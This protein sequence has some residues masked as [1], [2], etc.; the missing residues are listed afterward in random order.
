MSLHDMSWY[1]IWRLMPLVLAVLVAA[2]SKGGDK[3]AK[4][5]PAPL[6]SVEKV[7]VR[8]VAVE[9]RAPVD[10]RPL[11]QAD[12]GSKQLGYLDAVLV[13]R[14]DRV[15]KGQVVAL[16]RP[17]DLPDQLSAAR[18]VVAQSEASVA[19]ARVNYERA[20][21]LAPNGVVSQQAL[22]SAQAA[23]ATAEASHAAAKAQLAALAV[24][25]GETRIESPLDGLVA[26]RRLDP[27][28]LVGPTGSPS[29]LTVV[30]T[31]TLRVFIAVTERD[32]AGVKLGDDARVEVDALPGRLFHGKVMRI[33]PAFDPTTRT[34]D[35]EVHLA[36]ESGELRPGMYGRGAIVLATHP[37]ALSVPVGAVQI[38]SDKHYAYVLVPPDKVQRRAI[39][40]G[41]DG[42]AWIEVLSGLAP[43][44]EVVTAGLEALSDGATVRVARGVD[45]Y[46]G[47]ASAGRSSVPSAS[48]SAM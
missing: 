18:G 1:S 42:G 3:A 46:S 16:V 6:V 13:D 29:I 40:V 44:E 48:S 38:V 30:R 2:C 21:A 43:G 22:Q 32:A 24:R 10:L 33:A 39:E 11:A 5:R 20:A 9:V 19:L 34:L 8:D 14:G 26:V 23:L 17:S 7:A 4:A 45:P 31:D 37:N 15:K 36:N 47:K 41:V 28:A 12:I 25:L 35:A 27:G